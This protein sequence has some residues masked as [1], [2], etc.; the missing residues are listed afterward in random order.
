MLTA[1]IGKGHHCL[2]LDGK[3]MPKLIKTTVAAVILIV[4]LS[5]ILMLWMLATNDIKGI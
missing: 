1:E 2:T 5:F 4:V 3:L